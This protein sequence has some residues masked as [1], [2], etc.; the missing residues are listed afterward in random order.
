MKASKIILNKEHKTLK[1]LS[2]IKTLKDN[3]NR[4]RNY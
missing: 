3:M 1:G 4:N 2:E